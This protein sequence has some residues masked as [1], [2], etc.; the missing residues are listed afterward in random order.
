MKNQNN[1]NT[2]N[3]ATSWELQKI[4]EVASD[5]NLTGST[6]ASTGERIA[7]AFVLN[8]ME[9]LPDMYNDVVEAWDRLDHRWKACVRVIKRNGM[10]LIRQ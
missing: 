1:Q 7:A 6:A 10:H 2:L 4:I 5:L 9:Y 3:P 8:R